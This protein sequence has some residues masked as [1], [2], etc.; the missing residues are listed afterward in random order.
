MHARQI[1]P[2]FRI[3]DTRLVPVRHLDAEEHAEHQQHEL[4]GDAGPVLFFQR[5]REAA[6]DHRAFSF[7]IM[8]SSSV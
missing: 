1:G 8:A 2:R 6:Q 5:L 3:L 7:S 4:D